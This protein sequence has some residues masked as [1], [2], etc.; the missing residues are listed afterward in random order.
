MKKSN[1]K[2]VVQPEKNGLAHSYGRFS[3]EGERYI[4]EKPDTPRPWYNYLSNDVYHAIISQTGGGYSYYKDCK[5]HRLL[6]Y[7]DHRSDRPGRYLFIRDS[8]SQKFWTPNWQPICKP[9]ASWQAIHGFGYTQILSQQEGISVELTYFVPRKDPCEVWRV[10]IKNKSFYSKKI[11]LFPY[12]SFLLGDYYMERDF[13]NI[14][15][16][17]NEG[18]Y[19]ERNQMIVAFKHPT[20]ARPYKTFGFFGSSLKPKGYEIDAEKFLGE[21]GYLSNPQT[22]RRATTS[23]T[24][25]RGKEMVG[26]FHLELELKPHQEET[27]S[28]VMGMVE[29][30]SRAAKMAHTYRNLKTVEQEFQKTVAGWKQRLSTLEIKTPDEEFNIMNNLWGKYQLLQCT[31][32]RSAAPYNPGEG[33]RGFRDS[34]QDTEAISILEPQRAKQNIRMLLKNQYDTGH[35]V[36]GFSEITGPWEIGSNT[37][38][39]GKGDVAVW[40]PYMVTA[41]LKETGDDSFLNEKISY[42][43]GKKAT[44]WEHCVEAMHHFSKAQGPHGLPLFWK[45]DWNDAFDRCGI[46]GKGESVWLAMAYVRAL[47]QM[48]EL[49]TFLKKEAVSEKFKKEAAEV[50]QRINRH[51]WDGDWYLSL[52]TDHGSTVG[53][54]KNKEGKIY[55]NPQ[56]WAILS[57]V[58]PQLRKHRCMKSVEAWLDTDFGPYLFSPHYTHYDPKIGRITAF[59]PGTKENAALFSHAI[60][61]MIVA[62]AKEHLGTKAYTLFK[63]LTPFNPAKEIDRYKV[64]P[65]IYPEYCLGSGNAEMGEGAFT[66]NTGTAAWMFMA[67]HLWILGIRPTYQGLQVDPAIPRQWRGFSCRRMF[68]GCTYHIQVQ[69]PHGLESGKVEIYVN[70]KKIKGNIIPVSKKANKVFQV[71]AVMRKG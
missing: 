2:T 1:L 33:G 56:S 59:A 17:Y 16:L 22:V 19:D 71:L 6:Q 23:N 61:F 49:A 58:A 70:G 10:R 4:I 67:A 3:E 7:E 30:K 66:W 41:Y 38:I 68:R 39:L 32:W 14:L 8:E 65:Y 13:K 48:A 62:Y 69:N 27:V 20:T 45:A 26:V 52:F 46:Q 47:Y 5:L 54:R 43:R 24:S 9:L 36:A 28:F 40:I 64:E 11:E 44:V 42:L 37:G 53:S 57:E 15:L 51:A 50:T 25:V 35:A 55:L 12:V 34:A 18:Y 21:Y 31:Q 60:A 29:S 63:K